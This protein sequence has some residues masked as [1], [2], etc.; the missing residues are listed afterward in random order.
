MP[1][2]RSASWHRKVNAVSSAEA[3]IILLEIDHPLFSVPARVVNDNQDITSNGDVYTALTFEIT[4]PDDMEGQI[5]R[6]QLSMDNIGRELTQPLEDSNG[7]EGATVR[8]MQV[9][10]SAPNVIEWEALLDM[11]NV[12]MTNLKVNAE[13][14]YE[15]ILNR[16]A[17]AVRYDTF[18][19]PGLF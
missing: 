1:I 7:G 19:A 5:P 17:V 3:P 14:S 13:L 2:S 11:R 4:L 8:V 15:D 12:S 16:P 6:A 9:L 10:R 18:T